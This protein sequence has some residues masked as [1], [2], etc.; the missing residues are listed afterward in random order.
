MMRSFCTEHEYILIQRHTHMCICMCIYLLFNISEISRHLKVSASWCLRT[1]TLVPDCLG[2]NP[3][4]T[5]ETHI[6]DF[7]HST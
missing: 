6:G 4:S 2:L 1:Q 7:G 3:S 5:T